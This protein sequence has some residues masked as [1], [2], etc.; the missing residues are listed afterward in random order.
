MRL[1]DVPQRAFSAALRSIVIALMQTK[2]MALFKTNI[3]SD[4]AT[5]RNI[6]SWLR[7]RR[8]PGNLQ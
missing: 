2:P 8:S 3:P 4:D 7:V 5:D 1:S 6:G